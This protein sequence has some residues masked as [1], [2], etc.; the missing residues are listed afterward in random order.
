M[1]GGQRGGD[2]GQG[3]GQGGLEGL[4]ALGDAVPDE[5]GGAQG[6]EGRISAYVLGGLPIFLG[7]YLQVSNPD[8]LKPMLEGWGLVWLGG[9]LASI[10]MGMTMIF[11]MIKV[12]V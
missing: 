8:Y 11:R 5:R 10:A 4:L 9:A 3:V 7:L 2:E 6:A 1:P 12:D